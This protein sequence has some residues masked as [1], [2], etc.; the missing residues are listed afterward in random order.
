MA[1]PIKKDPPKR[2]PGGVQSHNRWVQNH[3]AIAH[4]QFDPSSDVPGSI[5]R[6]HQWFVGQRGIWV[7]NGWW[8]TYLPTPND[9]GVKVS[10][11]DDIPNI[12]KNKCHVPNHQPGTGLNQIVFHTKCSETST[13]S[14]CQRMIFGTPEMHA[15][16]RTNAL[17]AL[18]G[19]PV[20][21]SWACT[22]TR[23][24]HVWK[25]CISS[26]YIQIASSTGIWWSS[27]YI[28]I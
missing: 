23:K 24:N 2:P 4:L 18:F 20:V 3:A 25:W 1:G 14:N 6:D 7:L 28:M 5:R 21:S 19:L 10:W 27:R 16:L 15:R 12:S 26:K 8:Y 11:D 9:N 13:R 17:V 22:M